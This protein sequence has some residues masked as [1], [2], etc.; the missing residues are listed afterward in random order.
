MAEISLQLYNLISDRI[1]SLGI[2]DNGEY[3]VTSAPISQNIAYQVVNCSVPV[4]V[5]PPRDKTYSFSTGYLSDAANIE[6]A[7]LL[8]MNEKL[9]ESATNCRDKVIARCLVRDIVRRR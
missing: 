6:V 5:L 9:I 3:A 2:L 8:F 4:A 7:G 1:S